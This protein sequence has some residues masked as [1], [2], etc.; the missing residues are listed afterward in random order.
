MAKATSLSDKPKLQSSAANADRTVHNEI[1]LSLPRNEYE[2][3]SAN[4]DFIILENRSILNEVGM[5]IEY[6]Y[7]V[8]SGLA[9]ILSVMK[10][11]KSV[12]AGLTG[13][14]GFVG[15][16][17]LVGFCTSAT[18]AL[19]QVSGTAF[20]LAAGSLARALP[21]CPN[22]ERKL[23]NIRNG[24]PYRLPRE[25]RATVSIVLMRALPAGCS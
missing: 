4:L 24:S 13:K 17:L 6:S 21:D 7:F 12:E 18:R 5:P 15:L 10:N 20:R 8:N 1:L 23:Q 9:S 25:P 16:L 3:V 2:T 22:L 14:E 11:G 19:M